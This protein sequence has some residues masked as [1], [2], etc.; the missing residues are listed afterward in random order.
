[1]IGRRSSMPQYRPQLAHQA[2]GQITIE[3]EIMSANRSTDG[4]DPS[5]GLASC[6][7]F[8]SE[9]ILELKCSPKTKPTEKSRR[10]STTMKEQRLLVEPKLYT[11]EE[12]RP[13]RSQN[14][15]KR[16]TR[17]SKS[18]SRNDITKKPSAQRQPKER[19]G[20]PVESVQEK[21]VYK[22]VKPNT[23][24]K[25]TLK[26][27]KPASFSADKSS[28]VDVNEMARL[29]DRYLATKNGNVDNSH[30]VLSTPEPIAKANKAAFFRLGPKKSNK[31]KECLNENILTE[32]ADTNPPSA[33]SSTKS[34]F[35]KA[36]FLFFQKKSE[37]KLPQPENIVVVEAESANLEKK[38]SSSSEPTIASAEGSN[39]IVETMPALDEAN[40][41]SENGTDTISVFE[42]FEQYAGGAFPAS[43]CSPRFPTK[44]FE[45]NNQADLL[46]RI[47]KLQK[48]LSQ[49]KDTVKDLTEELDEVYSER[50]VAIHKLDM[51]IQAAKMN[52]NEEHE[53]LREI[54]MYLTDRS[55]PTISSLTTG[56]HDLHTS[57]D[58]HPFCLCL[59]PRM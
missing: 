6:S 38:E 51:L 26:P 42:A 5:E 23:S 30:D 15:T 24:S 44:K 45:I 47:E 35:T 46:T 57:E 16:T 29:Y 40:T 43:N 11:N 39:S 50:D 12:T 49:T 10:K 17:S 37:R 59:K 4:K 27:L 7:I 31:K 56:G 21:N 18:E 32:G 14:G 34:T 25:I 52:D 1:M 58:Y 22:S 54:R 13:S 20:P 48:E 9:I 33:P 41:A 8:N 2:S 19:Q 28:E 53:K 55:E 3:S 36:P